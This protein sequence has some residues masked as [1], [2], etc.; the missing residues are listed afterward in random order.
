MD[1]A[2][3][4]IREVLVEQFECD[5]ERC[6]SRARLRQDLMLDEGDVLEVFAAIEEKSGIAIFPDDAA[7]LETIGH[8]AE[9][10]AGQR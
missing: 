3:L 6:T 1:D 2:E 4:Q 8:I 10:I 9:Y 7:G 5:P